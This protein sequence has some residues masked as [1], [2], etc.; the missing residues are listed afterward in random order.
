ML[1]NGHNH[2]EPTCACNRT[3]ARPMTLTEHLCSIS[4]RNP[5]DM[6]N[7]LGFYRAY[8]EYG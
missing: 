7:P 8:D 4:I 3:F 1:I 6:C 2:P 5:A